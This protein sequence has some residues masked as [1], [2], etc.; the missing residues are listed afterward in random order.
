MDPAEGHAREGAADDLRERLDRDVAAH[1]AA[2][3]TL[4]EERLE[5]GVEAAVVV[6]GGV[7]DGDGP[8]LPEQIAARGVET[9]GALLEEIGDLPLDADLLLG[10]RLELFRQLAKRPLGQ[11]AE[12]VALL[13]EMIEEGSV[14]DLRAAADVGDLG[15]VVALLLEERIGGVEDALD[16]REALRFAALLAGIGSGVG[17]G[18]GSGSGVR[19]SGLV[20][21]FKY[22]INQARPRRILDAVSRRT[23][24]ERRADEPRNCPSRTAG[25]RSPGVGISRSGT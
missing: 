1:L 18:I 16:Q 17:S 3:H 6:G 21:D 15:P 8:D 11:A 22:K 23:P 24:H 13:V 9:R 4:R 5:G 12:Q 25:S 7:G 19:H 20:L 2:G 14:G 10:E